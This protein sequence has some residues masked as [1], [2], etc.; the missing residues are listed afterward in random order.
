M[1]Y[2][3]RVVTAR[4]QPPGIL[5]AFAMPRESA[6]P[7]PPLQQERGAVSSSSQASLQLGPE[8]SERLSAN[9]HLLSALEDLPEYC[10]RILNGPELVRSERLRVLLLH[11]LRAVDCGAAEPLRDRG[12]GVEVFGRAH[13]LD[14]TIDPCVGVAIGRLRAKLT[15]YYE[16]SVHNDASKIVLA[17]GSY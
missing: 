16:N 1:A 3:H 7:E 15:E 14:P 5:S 9:G 10:R 4:T 12:I 17:K 11:M 13:G 2:L 6:I 8:N